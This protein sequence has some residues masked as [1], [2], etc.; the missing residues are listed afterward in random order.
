[1]Q[2]FN[3]VIQGFGT[4]WRPFFNPGIELP[5]GAFWKVQQT[6]YDEQVKYINN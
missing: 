1:M 3:P 4:V 5:N 6:E 2:I